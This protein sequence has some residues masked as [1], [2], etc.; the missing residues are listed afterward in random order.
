MSK[1]KAQGTSNE[2]HGVEWAE[3]HPRVDAA[4]RLAEGGSNDPGDIVIR[5]IDGDHYVIEMKHR[6]RLNVHKALE[7]HLGKVEKAD[8]P[9][10]VTGSALQWKRT[11]LK[12]GNVRR[13][14]DGL[15]EVFV[16]TPDEYLDLI[17]R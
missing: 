14:A 11:V 15:P 12:P 4:W 7:K 13:S 8:Y 10:G 6:E 17:T 5:T 9:F 2:S 16:L 3:A 1:Q